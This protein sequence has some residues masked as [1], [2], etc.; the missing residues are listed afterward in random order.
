MWPTNKWTTPSSFL[1]MAQINKVL[2]RSWLLWG[3]E[4]R[5][6]KWWMFIL[7]QQLGLDGPS[8]S[9][10]SACNKRFRGDERWVLEKT[11]PMGMLLGWDVPREGTSFRLSTKGQKKYWDW[12][13][14]RD[15]IS[16]RKNV[17]A[18]VSD[19]I[20]S[21]FREEFWVKLKCVL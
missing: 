18:L 5:G 16:K 4:R 1:P 19:A 21:D 11:Q 15:G 14:G 3:W 17:S 9:Q 12:Q 13:R 10:L 6:A 2:F 20:K 7:I 8:I